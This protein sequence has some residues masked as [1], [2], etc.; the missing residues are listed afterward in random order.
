LLNS[1]VVWTSS[2]SWYM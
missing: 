1:V 2:N